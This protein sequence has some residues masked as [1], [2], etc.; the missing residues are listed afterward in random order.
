M[1]IVEVRHIRRR[2]TRGQQERTEIGGVV[3]VTGREAA[4]PSGS[5]QLRHLDT[6]LLTPNTGDARR[7]VA[8]SVATPNGAFGNSVLL[9]TYITGSTGTRQATLATIG[10]TPAAGAVSSS[11]LAFGQ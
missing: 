9:R 3:Q 8:G 5:F 10:S 7:A 6:L 1:A 11:F 4:V 2:Y